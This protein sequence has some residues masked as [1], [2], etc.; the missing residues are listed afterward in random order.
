MSCT[1]EGAMSMLIFIVS[2]VNRN[3][4]RAVLL[5]EVKCF[6]FCKLIHVFYLISE[7]RSYCGLQESN[8]FVCC[9]NSVNIQE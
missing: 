6:L 8:S 5:F 3:Q 9:I 2:L 7:A 1:R 4:H